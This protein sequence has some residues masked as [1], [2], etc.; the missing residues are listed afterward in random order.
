MWR[1]LAPGNT[2]IWPWLATILLLAAVVISLPHGTEPPISNVVP[3]RVSYIK[4]PGTYL[5]VNHPEQLRPTDLGD[6]G[7]GAVIYQSPPVR[8]DV[9]A[10]YEHMNG[11]GAPIHYNIQVYNSGQSPVQ[12][13]NFQYGCSNKDVTS[14]ECWTA[15]LNS[16]AKAFTLASRRQKWLLPEQTI[17]VGNV[18]SGVVSFH[19]DDYVYVRF[20][21]YREQD[22]IRPGAVPET[23]DLDSRPR[24]YSGISPY[25]PVLK[26]D[27][28]WVVDD[29]TRPGRLP[30]A[31]GG[32][33]YGDW[34]TNITDDK[35][36]GAIVDDLLPLTLPSQ[37]P[38]TI[39]G[40]SVD[41]VMDARSG[42]RYYRYNLGNWGVRYVE[43]FTII[44]Q[45]HHPRTFAFGLSKDSGL[46]SREETSNVL[47]QIQDGRVSATK[48]FRIGAIR[49]EQIVYTS[50]PIPSGGIL[51]VVI[52]ST[53]TSNCYGNL[54][55]FARLLD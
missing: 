8:G 49:Q 38:L 41:P 53:L 32:K 2:Q 26:G 23:Y 39:S 33:T 31:Y 48:M 55:H 46:A 3:C 37:P 36:S 22:Q 35:A 9:S 15:Y 50:P 12:I 21:A 20:Y 34:T 45:G 5:F 6:Y 10:F 40:R 25:L 47:V 4:V 13:T 14:F 27:W 17:A 30:V 44:N 16:P 24:V 28:R 19:A 18:F 7:P 29:R 11:T 51:Q 52:T 42:H 1:N 54:H 43:T